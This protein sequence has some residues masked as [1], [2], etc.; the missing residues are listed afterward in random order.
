MDTLI[1]IN[2]Y[3]N[4]IENKKYYMAGFDLDWTIIKPIH[5]KIFPKNKDDWQLW[6]QSVLTKLEGLLDSNCIIVIISNQKQ[7]D[8]IHNKKVYNEFIEK[9]N[10]IHK[11]LKIDFIFI[12][13]LH[14][15]IYR[16]PRIGM[17]D[18]LLKKTNI[19]ID[20]NKSYYIGDMAGREKDKYDTDLKFAKNLD[21]KFFTPEQFFLNDNSQYHS[22][23]KL[24]GYLL[25][26]TSKGS[27]KEQ[28]SLNL[29]DTSRSRIMIIIS[30]YPGSG[31]S[32]LANKL[33]NKSLENNIPLKLFS[34]DL[35]KNNF[36]GMLI[37][38]LNLGE[39][40]IIEG[41]YANNQLRQELKLLANKYNYNTIYIH[42][43]TSYDLSYHLN[44][45]RFLYKDKNKVPEIVFMKYR[46]MFEYPIELDWDKL[47]EYH[48]HIS[49]KVNK[50]FL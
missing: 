33:I 10:N 19:F 17:I 38:S 31:K 20:L 43:K 23:Y 48:P 45:Y 46:K 11:L 4:I 9:I 35:F 47:I 34:R 37:K 18:Y 39:S 40:C 15:D 42:V 21:V 12:A 50:L 49:S 29:D 22:K 32:Y 7:I 41:L 14:D 3:K 6:N 27:F 24:S 28:S 26:N 16:K 30:G 8:N 2:Y 44:L 5:G 1:Y 25:D 13:S 36:N